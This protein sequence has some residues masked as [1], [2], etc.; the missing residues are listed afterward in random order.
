MTSSPLENRI[1][2]DK[3]ILIILHENVTITSELQYLID[4]FCG[5]VVNNLSEIK[6]SLDNKKIYV[7]GD[8][9][10]LQND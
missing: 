2:K 9:D 1:S 4:N 3:N 7:C 6:I 10:Q 8:I 5:I